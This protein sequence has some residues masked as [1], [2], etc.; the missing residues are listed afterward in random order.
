MLIYI[1][2]NTSKYDWE[3]KLTPCSS[4]RQSSGNN[5]GNST[6]QMLHFQAH[7][8][9]K[10]LSQLDQK[11]NP[12]SRLQANPYSQSLWL[13]PAVTYLAIIH[14]LLHDRNLCHQLSYSWPPWVWGKPCE[15]TQFLSCKRRN[16]IIYSVNWEKAEYRLVRVWALSSFRF[17]KNSVMSHIIYFILFPKLLHLF[18]GLGLIPAILQE[19]QSSRFCFLY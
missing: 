9:L 16:G 2:Q 18:W 11:C 4:P 8:S 10:V 14:F 13:S 1:T 7:R 3:T 5:G 6:L 12:G 15:R 19:R 17:A